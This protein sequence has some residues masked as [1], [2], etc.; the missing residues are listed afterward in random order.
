MPSRLSIG[1]GK[2]I[3]Y[4]LRVIGISRGLL[5]KLTSLIFIPIVIL[6]TL[7]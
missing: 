5:A 3:L 4:L 1:L 7:G 2:N 6:V